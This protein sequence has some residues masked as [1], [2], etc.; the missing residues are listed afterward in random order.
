MVSSKKLAKK[1]GKQIAEQKANQQKK[2]EEDGRRPGV[3]TGGKSCAMNHRK[4]RNRHN[5]SGGRSKGRR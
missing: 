3:P 2:K 4:E 5:K 1:R